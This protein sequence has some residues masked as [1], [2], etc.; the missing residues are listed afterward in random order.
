MDLHKE[1]LWNDV[2]WGEKQWFYLKSFLL[3]IFKLLNQI[4]TQKMIESKNWILHIQYQS[5][6]YSNITD[7]H[8]GMF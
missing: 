4:N 7:L 6:F 5:V 8:L 2:M 1:K 3:K